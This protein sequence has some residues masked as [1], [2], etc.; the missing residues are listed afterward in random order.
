MDGNQVLRCDPSYHAIFEGEQF[1]LGIS[2]LTGRHYCVSEYHGQHG[3]WLTLIVA[4]GYCFQALQSLTLPDKI[5][6]DLYEWVV[7]ELIELHEWGAARSLLRQTV[8]MIMLK[9]NKLQ[10]EGYVNL[11]SL[12]ARSYFNPGE[13]YP[14]RSSNKQ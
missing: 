13:E 5:L 3:K 12:L 1:T 7:L 11:E 14:N 6:I 8:P 10:P 2:Y 9:T 4:I